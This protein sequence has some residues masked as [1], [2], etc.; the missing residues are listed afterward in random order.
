MLVATSN[1]FFQATPTNA[2]LTPVAGVPAKAGAVW[3]ARND[4]QTLLAVD[5]VLYLRDG[6]GPWRTRALP[7]VNT[8]SARPPR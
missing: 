4:A 2:T 5:G 3:L 6:Q 7:A 1:G 8:K